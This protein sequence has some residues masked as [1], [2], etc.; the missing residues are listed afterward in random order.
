M[1]LILEATKL[2]SRVIRYAATNG[3]IRKITPLSSSKKNDKGIISWIWNG[4]GSFLNSLLSK[5]FTLLVA[6]LQWSFTALW[7]LIVQATQFIYNFDWNIADEELDKNIASAFDNLATSLGGFTGSAV[8]YL[9][10]GAL[11]GALI[12]TFNEPLGVHV[13]EAVGEEALDEL[14]SHLATVIRLTFMGF[15]RS[16]MAYLYKNV[17]KLWRESDDT[18]KAKLKAKGLKGDAI[19]KAIDDRNKPWSFAKKVE[20]KIEAIPS[21]FWRNFAEEFVQEFGQA[22]IEAGYVVAGTLDSYYAQQKTGHGE[23]ETV[24][25]EFNEDETIKVNPVPSTA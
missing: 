19:Q 3:Q 20:Q 9:A 1:G 4:L 24:E 10:C 14:A 22:C 5:T 16:T 11:P 25:I 13:L 23:D 15:A 12:M 7:G 18:M 2:G 17:R 8:G 21:K 6:G